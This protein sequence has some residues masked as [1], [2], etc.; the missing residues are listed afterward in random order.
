MGSMITVNQSRLIKIIDDQIPLLLLST[1]TYPVDII[2][3]VR[4]VM[5]VLF[6]KDWRKL[7][8]IFT[9]LR[10][11]RDG[12]SNLYTFIISM[13]KCNGTAGLVKI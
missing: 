9:F 10:T 7:S 8:M 5:N 1:M 4:S 2:N 11:F 13:H 3:E 12:N 6:Q